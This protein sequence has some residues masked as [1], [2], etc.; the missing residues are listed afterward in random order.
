MASLL[1]ARKEVLAGL[2]RWLLLTNYQLKE[3]LNAKE[4]IQNSKILYSFYWKKK[5]LVK[6]ILIPAETL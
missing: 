3:F 2:T 4:D 6:M 5:E 1:R